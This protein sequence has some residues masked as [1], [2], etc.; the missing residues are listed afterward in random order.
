MKNRFTLIKLLSAKPDAARRSKPLPPRLNREKLNERFTLIE[1]LVVVAVI[2]VLAAL[3]LPALRHARERALIG[4]CISNMRQNTTVLILYANDNDLRYFDSDPSHEYGLSAPRFRSVTSGY[5]Y[6]RFI[7]PYFAGGK[8][9][10]TSISDDVDDLP[11]WRCPSIHAPAIDHKDNTRPWCY[12]EYLYFPGNR[13]PW[14]QATAK[15]LSGLIDSS[16]SNLPLQA[17]DLAQFVVMQDMVQQDREHLGGA[18]AYNHGD[19]T[20]D[21]DLWGVRATN[22]SHVARVCN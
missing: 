7:L 8:D 18:Y 2:A 12:N 15:S 14:C 3:L 1:L 13:H 17:G 19:G 5:D 10:S 20:V 11:T 6:R 16:W 21:D 9:F 4:V 22:P